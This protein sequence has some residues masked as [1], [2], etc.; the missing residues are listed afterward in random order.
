MFLGIDNTW[1]PSLRSSENR[2]TEQLWSGWTS[3]DHLVQPLGDRVVAPAVTSVM[4]NETCGYG[5]WVTISN[6]QQT[7]AYSSKGDLSF[8]QFDSRCFSDCS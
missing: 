7:P 6:K 8:P 5:A 1:S 4:Q 2:I 3:K